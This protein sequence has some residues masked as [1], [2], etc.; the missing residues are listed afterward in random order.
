[1]VDFY[2]KAVLTVIAGALIALAVQ[3][4]TAPNPATAQ[5]GI[6]GVRIRS[7]DEHPTL[8]WEPLPV[9]IER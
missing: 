6:V 3:R 2:T 8:L 9:R 7:I 4:Y 1:M 5:S